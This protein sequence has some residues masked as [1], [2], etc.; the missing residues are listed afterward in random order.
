MTGAQFPEEQEISLLHNF[1]ID[2]GTQISPFAM[3]AGS[4][5]P[6]GKEGE[7]WSWPPASTTEAKNSGA[8]TTFPHNFHGTV[9]N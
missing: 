7:G 2:S 8:I 1:K 3:S 5:S 4:L 9:F 6:R